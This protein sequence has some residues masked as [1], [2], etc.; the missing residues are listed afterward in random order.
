MVGRNLKVRFIKAIIGNHASCICIA[1]GKIKSRPFITTRYPQVVIIGICR[2]EKFIGIIGYNR[3]PLDR[4][5]FW[6]TI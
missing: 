4:G 2:L 6:D 1:N 5:S 3:L